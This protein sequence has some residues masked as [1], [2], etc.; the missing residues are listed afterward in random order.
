[1]NDGIIERCDEIPNRN[2]THYLPHQGVVRENNTSMKLLVVDDASSKLTKH[3]Y[4]LNGCLFKGSSLSPFLFDILLLFRIHP[5]AFVADLRKAFLQI[6]VNEDDRDALRFLWVSNSRS[7]D[8][9][10]TTY[11]FTRVLI[12]M[13][14][15]PFLLNGTLRHLS[16]YGNEFPEA[17]AKLIRSLYVDDF[18]GGSNSAQGCS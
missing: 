11:R 6:R 12:G 17:I 13:N 16:K 10:I 14:C 18:A 8:P 2:I 15:S 4:S 5:T 1:M 7:D 3:Q 9:E